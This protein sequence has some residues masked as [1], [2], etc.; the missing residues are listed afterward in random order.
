VLAPHII[1]GLWAPT[2]Q[3]S[4]MASIEHLPHGGFERRYLAM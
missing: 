1:S 3:A 4:D 2:Q